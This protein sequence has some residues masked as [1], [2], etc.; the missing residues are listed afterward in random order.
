VR[1]MRRRVT[2][3]GGTVERRDGTTQDLTA[4]RLI[5]P[6]EGAL[7]ALTAG[8]VALAVALVIMRL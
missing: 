1:D 6:S 5:A 3:V 8:I 2:R 7:Q 4:D